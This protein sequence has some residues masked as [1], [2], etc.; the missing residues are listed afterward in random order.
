MNHESCLR[1]VRLLTFVGMASAGRA[2]AASP[3]GGVVGKVI[4]GYQVWFSGLNDGPPN[5]NWS[6]HANLGAPLVRN[7]ILVRRP[8]VGAFTTTYQNAFANVGRLL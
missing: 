6:H 2:T 4:A 3:V 8:D 1:S 5:G 7:C